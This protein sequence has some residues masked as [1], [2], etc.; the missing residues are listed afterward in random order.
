MM[1]KKALDAAQ[2]TMPT[3][4]PYF[5]V[6][7]RSIVFASITDSLDLNESWFCC[8]CMHARR[9][10]GS[11]TLAHGSLTVCQLSLLF[12][13]CTAATCATQFLNAQMFFASRTDKYPVHSGSAAT[14]STRVGAGVATQQHTEV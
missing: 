4:P 7:G 9:G 3:S 2:V 6:F 10:N 13:V 12:F 5:T 11:N 8:N 1:G 14:S